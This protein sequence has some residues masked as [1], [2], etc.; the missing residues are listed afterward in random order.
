MA[1][2]RQCPICGEWH[3]AA[4]ACKEASALRAF[5]A[6]PPDRQSEVDAA[7]TLALIRYRLRTRS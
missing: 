6:A 7:E 2:S 1:A 4:V 3:D 5:A